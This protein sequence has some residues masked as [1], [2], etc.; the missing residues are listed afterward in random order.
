M[1]K[2]KGVILLL[3]VLLVPLALVGCASGDEGEQEEEVPIGPP[4]AFEECVTQA[5]G[6]DGDGR[7]MWHDEMYAYIVKHAEQFEGVAGA[8]R[9]YQQAQ[10][11]LEQTR[12]D[13]L[14]KNDPRRIV[15]DQGLTLFRDPT[16]TNE[17]S[18]AL[19]AIDPEFSALKKRAVEMQEANREHPQAGVFAE[20]FHVTLATSK[21]Y[22]KVVEVWQANDEEVASLLK[23]CEPYEEAPA[24]E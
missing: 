4:I 1:R 13:Y 24:G 23:R 16:W 7:R 14:L 10:L 9:E 11:D 21:S 20:F 5:R 12:F 8:R 2:S 3:L 6:I 17:D 18:E 15:T 22:A 19:A